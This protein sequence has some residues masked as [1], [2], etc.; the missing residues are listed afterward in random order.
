MHYQ[1]YFLSWV[2][3]KNWAKMQVEFLGDASL[4]NREAW[5]V[6]EGEPMKERL[7]TSKKGWKILILLES[8]NT[9]SSKYQDIKQFAS[10]RY[11]NTLTRIRCYHYERWIKICRIQCRSFP[12][13]A[14][15]KSIIYTQKPNRVTSHWTLSDILVR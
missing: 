11:F 3:A 4:K 9:L 2:L 15:W 1:Q 10:N 12:K 6:H 14:I 13:K 8:L 5:T 7:G